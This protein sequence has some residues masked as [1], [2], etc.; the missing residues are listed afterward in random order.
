MTMDLNP[1][2]EN[3]DTLLNWLDSDRERAGEKYEY[4][5]HSLIKIFVWRGC[6][7]AEEL[8]DE[9]IDR[10]MRKA[11]ELAKTYK[12]NPALYFYG[13]AKKVLL[14]HQRREFTPVSFNVAAPEPEDLYN[15]EDAKLE[16]LE[17]CL[18]RLSQEDR[19]LILLY[20]QKEKQAKIEFRKFL[21]EQVGIETNN[22]R[23]RAYRIRNFLHDCISKCLEGD[24][25]A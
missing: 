4:I 3:F 15:Q 16:C 2:E 10:V 20:Y 7:R 5:R 25:P 8:A 11:R 14:E 21:A 24:G 23:V 9:T 22:L 18:Q 12:G 6:N 1:A 19:D 17:T 13:V